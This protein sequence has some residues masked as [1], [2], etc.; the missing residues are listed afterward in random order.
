MVPEQ[1]NNIRPAATDTIV[2]ANPAP[3]DTVTIAGTA[4]AA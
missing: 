3:S 1:F 4:T 2:H